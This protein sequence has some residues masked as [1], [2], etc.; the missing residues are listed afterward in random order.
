MFLNPVFY[1]IALG[2]FFYYRNKYQKKAE[3]DIDDFKKSKNEK[4]S[5]I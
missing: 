4:K 3:R 5:D 2:I 1:L